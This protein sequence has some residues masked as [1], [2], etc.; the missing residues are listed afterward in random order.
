MSLRQ[1]TFTPDQQKEDVRATST[2]TVTAI[3]GGATSLGGTIGVVVIFDDAVVTDKSQA[4]LALELVEQML[5]EI[6]WPT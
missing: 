3:A 2:G 1:Y 5:A 6:N 4:N